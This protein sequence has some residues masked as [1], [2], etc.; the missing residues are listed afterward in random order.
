MAVLEPN[1]LHSRVNVLRAV[2]AISNMKS[3]T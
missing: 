3:A 1:K 2:A